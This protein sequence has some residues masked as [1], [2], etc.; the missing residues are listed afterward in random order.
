MAVVASKEILTLIQNVSGRLRL[1]FPRDKRDI[2]DVDQFLELPGVLEVTYNMLTKSL[3]VQYNP[4]IIT[5]D[6]LMNGMERYC[7]WIEIRTGKAWG[8]VPFGHDMLSQIIFGS[9][10]KGNSYVRKKLGGKADLTSIVP[11]AMVGWSIWELIRR[12]TR[13][14]WFDILRAVEIYVASIASHQHHV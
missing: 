10:A 11:T 7:P 13:P 9:L 14:G 5:S 6:E 12:P 8:D 4:Q 1:Q 3:L 2:P